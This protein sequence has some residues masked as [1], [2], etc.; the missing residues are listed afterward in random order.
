LGLQLTFLASGPRELPYVFTS[1]FDAVLVR[2]EHAGTLSVEKLL[3]V[4]SAIPKLATKVNVLHYFQ[5]IL[6]GV[7]AKLR[8]E[9][10]LI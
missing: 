8:A 9:K 7:R 3:L 1:T 10:L 6:Y 4:A 5:A 2:D